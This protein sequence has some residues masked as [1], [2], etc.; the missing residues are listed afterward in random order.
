M[1]NH[2]INGNQMAPLL[3]LFVSFLTMLAINKLLLKERFSL[4]F[5]GKIG[6]GHYAHFYRNDPLHQN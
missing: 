3:I 6:T 5:L 2:A 4:S 1:S